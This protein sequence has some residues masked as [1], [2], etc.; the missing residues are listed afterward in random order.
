MGFITIKPPFGRIFLLFPSTLSKP[1]IRNSRL[2]PPRKSQNISPEKG[3]F[4]KESILPS[5]IFQGSVF[6][7]VG[8]F[9]F[10]G[11]RFFSLIT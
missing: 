9:T 8:G 1:K 4:Q 11:G 10:F 2:P 7:G 3:P 6:Q 5:T